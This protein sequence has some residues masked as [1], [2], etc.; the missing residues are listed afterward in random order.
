M[1]V[2]QTCW[3]EAETHKSCFNLTGNKIN[4]TN[5]LNLL[6]MSLKHESV[7]LSELL[8]FCII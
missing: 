8:D 5:L 1:I 3:S 4:A 7:G 6:F 2:S